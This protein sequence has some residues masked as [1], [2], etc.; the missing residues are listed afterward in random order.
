MALGEAAPPRGCKE[1]EGQDNVLPEDRYSL[2]RVDLWSI[3]NS[4]S[5]FLNDASASDSVGGVIVLKQDI[6][7]SKNVIRK[8][9]CVWTDGGDHP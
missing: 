6:I 3:A 8:I 5:M 2:R 4:L 7:A 9:S 1:M